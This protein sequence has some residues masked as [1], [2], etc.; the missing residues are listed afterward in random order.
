MPSGSGG[1][2]QKGSFAAAGPNSRTTLFFINF[3]DNSRLE[4]EGFAP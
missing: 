4:Q 1:V 2:R 3:K